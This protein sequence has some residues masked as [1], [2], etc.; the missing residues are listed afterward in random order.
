[1]SSFVLFQFQ[2]IDIVLLLILLAKVAWFSAHVY[3]YEICYITA[4][5]VFLHKGYMIEIELFD[6]YVDVL[7]YNKVIL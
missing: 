5:V 1:M 7:F 2:R 4:V 6:C 3:F